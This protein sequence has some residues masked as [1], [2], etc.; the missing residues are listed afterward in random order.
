M[1]FASLLFGV[2]ILADATGTDRHY[3][4]RTN[5]GF[6]AQYAE[7]KRKAEAASRPK[8]PIRTD[9][10]SPP[11][12]AS[13]PVLEGAIALKSKSTKKSPF[14]LIV[15]TKAGKQ[16]RVVLSTTDKTSLM[17]AAGGSY[18]PDPYIVDDYTSSGV[19]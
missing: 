18:K 14:R 15:D 17:F 6:E 13:R 7:K 12:F 1:L 3:G 2:V 16:L 5:S 11:P 10:V 19:T 8:T 4:F 9:I